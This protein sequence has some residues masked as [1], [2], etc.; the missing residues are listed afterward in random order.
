MTGK[1][2]GFGA[3]IIII[4][5]P[6]NITNVDSDDVREKAL[7]VWSTSLPSR[8]N[9]PRTGAWIVIMQRSHPRDLTGY[10]LAREHGFTQLEVPY[11]R[12]DIKKSWVHVCLPARFEPEHPFPFKTPVVRR[13]GPNKGKEWTDA[14]EPGELLWP[15]RWGDEAIGELA[16]RM[17]AHSYAGQYQQRP[18]AKEGNLF[19]RDWFG[20]PVVAAPERCKWSRVRAWD[21]AATEQHGKADPDW[22]V[23]LLMSKDMSTNVIYI[24]DVVRFRGSPEKVQ[25]ELQRCAKIDG[26]STRIRIPQDPGAA[27]K[28]QTAYLAGMLQGYRIISEREEGKKGQRAQA[29][30]AQCEAGNV[31][32][33]RG[34]WNDVFIEE[35]CAFPNSKD[36]QLDAATAAFRA[37]IK[38]NVKL[39]SSHGGRDT[40]KTQ[41]NIKR[42]L[43]DGSVHYSG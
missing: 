21:I 37:L 33:V 14:R 24:E 25:S 38:R 43:P 18:S 41:L 31:R 7:T 42:I 20:T 2:T 28:M 39:T 11:D 4:D 35:L 40:P 32:L 3:D 13:R 26:K 36:D 19:K 8:L 12:E 10:I 1:V 29:F 23:G 34:D 17:P 27:G 22:T 16:A 15:E 30:A 5:D 9:D 6:H